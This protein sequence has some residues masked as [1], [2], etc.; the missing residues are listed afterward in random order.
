[1]STRQQAQRSVNP[2]QACGGQAA[3]QVVEDRLEELARRCG[4]QHCASH[5]PCGV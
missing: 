3:Q 1:M 5:R 2:K 4:K